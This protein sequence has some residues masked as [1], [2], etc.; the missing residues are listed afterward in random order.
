MPT[1]GGIPFFS[2]RAGAR[3]PAMQFE[4]LNRGN[5]NGLA[6]RQIGIRGVP[7]QVTLKKDVLDGAAVQAERVAQSSL[8]GAFLTLNLDTGES[9]AGV[10]VMFV[11]PLEAMPIREGQGGLLADGTAQYWVESRWDV[12]I[13]S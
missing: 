5:V 10:L 8:Q 1:V 4:L 3:V 11:D 12:L 2:V 6:V 13:P 7:F 9:Y